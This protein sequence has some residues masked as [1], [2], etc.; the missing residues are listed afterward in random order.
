MLLFVGAAGYCNAQNANANAQAD[1]KSLNTPDDLT[2]RLIKQAK[3]V[4]WDEHFGLSLGQLLQKYVMGEVT[5]EYLG[6][7]YYLVEYGGCPLILI[8]EPQ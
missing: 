6:N 8:E 1:P 2:V 7:G 5:I 4:L 3:N